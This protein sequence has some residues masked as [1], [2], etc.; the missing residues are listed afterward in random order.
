MRTFTRALSLCLLVLAAA[1]STPLHAVEASRSD[2]ARHKVVKSIA[3]FTRGMQ[4]FD[5]LLPLYWD[6]DKGKL[7]LEVPTPGQSLLYFTTLTGGLG[8]NDVGLDRGQVAEAR[9]VHFDRVGPKLLLV[10][11]NQA[12]RSG[13]DNPD[14]QAAVNQSFARS[15]LWGF[16]IVAVTGPRVLVDA[17]DFVV[18]DGHGAI[19]ALA[20]AK[21]GKFKLD[22]ARS[23]VYLP[24]TKA[25]PRNTEMETTVTLVHDTGNDPGSEPG[26]YVQDVT[27][28]P[29]AITLNERYS[30]VAL[31]PP[32]YTP[33][34]SV[35]GD[36]YF[37]IAYT[38]E[39][40]PLGAPLVKHF[41]IRQRLQKKDP[42]VVLSDPVKPI[43]YYLDRG[44]PEPIREAL[45][46]GARW[47]NQAF[48]A[49]GYRDAFRVELLPEGVDPM[50]VRYNVIQWVHRATRGWSYG[51]AIVDPRTGEIIKANITLG[52]LRARYDYLL[53]EGLL[54][55]YA[56]PGQVPDVMQRFVM[57]RL[58][59]L[60]AHE[61]GHTLGLAHNYI[62]SSQ[63][64]A[65]VMDYPAPLVNL[66]PSGEIDLSDA[67]ATGIGDW[68]KVSIDYGYQ[69]FAP[70]TDVP[71]A[72]DRILGDARGH[73]LTFLTDQDAR[74]AGAAEPEVN[75]WDNGVD[76]AAELRSVMKVR[77]AALQH[78]G[79][80]AVRRGTPLATLEDA[81]VPVYLFHRYQL[82]AT[83]KVL[84]GLRYDYALRGDGQRPTTPVPAAEQRDAL[85]ALLQTLSPAAL[86]LPAPLLASIPPRPPGYPPNRELFARYTGL[87]FDPLTPPVTAADLTLSNL[88]QAERDARLVE[89]HA[90]D[91]TLPDLGEVIDK[92][93]VATFDGS[94]SDGYQTEILHAEQTLLVQHLMDLADGAGMPAVRAVA[95]LKLDQLQRRAASGKGGDTA[96]QAQR[97]ALASAIARFERRPASAKP[98]APPPAAP[99]GS[100]LGG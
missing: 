66:T 73:G 57:A 100:P 42:A 64:R 28:T 54:S 84:G 70:G 21:Q 23:A 12:F 10:Q 95:M 37:E 26:Q 51:A 3:G 17:T 48:T 18:R 2:A 99:P 92:L 97:F 25:F 50:D 88:L 83:A 41:I 20:K 79:V 72:L 35:P 11:P 1:L 91:P 43:V 96:A 58:S 77:A 32:G 29:D 60:A 75:L 52:S 19:A 30:F 6:A 4:R 40:A 80:N 63:K 44:A 85:D 36:G 39:A 49:A 87:T 81:L 90:A 24:G 94:A 7:Y 69:D 31:P 33:R 8:S 59:Q 16:G 46:S 56:K 86:A 76:M 55:P 14:E 53:A 5:G 9:L 74:P 34:V 71:A 62:A 93:I 68:D 65:S 89:Q 47:W 38:D 22:A 13:S 61:L 67:Y 27:P 15:V 82:D 98:L 45:L 78:F